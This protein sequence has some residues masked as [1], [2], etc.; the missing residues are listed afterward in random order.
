MAQA[1]GMHAEA[2]LG[3][4][5]VRMLLRPVRDLAVVSL[6]RVEQNDTRTPGHEAA[7]GPGET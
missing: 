1:L 2:A 7:L 3:F 6:D 5:V 4:S